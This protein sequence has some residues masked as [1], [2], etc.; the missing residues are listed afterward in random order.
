MEGSQKVSQY[1]WLSLNWLSYRHAMF[2]HQLVL[3]IHCF[4]CLAWI[5]TS[6]VNLVKEKSD[7]NALSLFLFLNNSQMGCSILQVIVS[8]FL[9]FYL[10]L[11]ASPLVNSQFLRF[12]FQLLSRKIFFFFFF[13]PSP[14]FFFLKQ[15]FLFHS[16][17]TTKEEPYVLATK[18]P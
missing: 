4:V 12:S 15:K 18:W 17:F 14:K 16:S 10:P 6:K 5:P 2:Q 3:S 13:L 7:Q 11:W 8:A 1:C 9:H